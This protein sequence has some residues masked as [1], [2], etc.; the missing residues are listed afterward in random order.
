[1]WSTIM[2]FIAAMILYPEAQRKAHEEINRV[3]GQDKLP[4]FSDR[5]SLPYSEAI[6]Y[7]T[8]R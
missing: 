1:M 8:M 2:T 4:D 3:I 7:E 6:V 5:A